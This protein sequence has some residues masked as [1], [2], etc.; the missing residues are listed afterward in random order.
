MT[1]ERDMATAGRPVASLTKDD[2]PTLRNIPVYAG[3]EEIGHVGDV[4]YD[5]ETA[6]VECIGVKGDALGF[7]R[8]WMPARDATLADDGLHLTYGREGLDGAPQWD[9]DADLDD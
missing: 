2:I 5:E 4:Y 6:R 3:G 1:E 8:R 9:D 7:S